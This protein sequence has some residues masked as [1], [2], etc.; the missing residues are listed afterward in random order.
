MKARRLGQSMGEY[1]RIGGV[2]LIEYD[3][4]AAPRGRVFAPPRSLVFSRA[5]F[6]LDECRA[7]FPV[8]VPRDQ[9]SNPSW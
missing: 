4:A 7:T 8:N 9:P 5:G 6:F 2:M 3:R 1:D